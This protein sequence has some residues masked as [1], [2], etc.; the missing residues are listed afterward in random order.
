MKEKTKCKNEIKRESNHVV[1]DGEKYFLRF[2]KIEAK[3]CNIIK[4]VAIGGRRGEE[5]NELTD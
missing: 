5:G 4:V 2:Q 1:I 3:P